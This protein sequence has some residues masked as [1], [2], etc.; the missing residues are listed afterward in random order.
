MQTLGRR[1]GRPPATQGDARE[2]IVN[3]AR[4]VFSEVGYDAATYQAIAERTG[5]TRPAVNHHFRHKRDLYREVV[6]Q[7]NTLLVRAG[8]EQAAAESTLLGQVEAFIAT[9]L[10]ADTEQH[11][12]AAFLATSFLEFQ[13]HPEL[14]TEYD[15]ADQL[16]VFLNSVVAGAIMRGELPAETPPSEMAEALLAMLWGIGFYAGFVGTRDQL[17]GL[18]RQLPLLLGGATAPWPAA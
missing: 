7:T 1:P 10:A 13:R 15:G 17:T 18:L 6:R 11:S 2:R 5:L 16:R 9:A 14:L 3:A 12:A 8:I 4:Q